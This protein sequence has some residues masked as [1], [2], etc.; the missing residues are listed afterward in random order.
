MNNDNI[1]F[2]PHK[3]VYNISANSSGDIVELLNPIFK[4]KY[5][6]V[7]DKPSS[8]Y[9]GDNKDVVCKLKSVGV[10]ADSIENDELYVTKDGVNI[11]I[12]LVDGETKVV[13]IFNQILF[14]LKEFR[15]EQEQI[16]AKTVEYTIERMG[17]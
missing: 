13:N 10:Y 6:N 16:L 17:N 7:F 12:K 1:T 11:Q 8:D 4:T 14:L 3:V 15:A 2:R 9:L 5:G